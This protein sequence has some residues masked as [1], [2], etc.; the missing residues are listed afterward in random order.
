MGHTRSREPAQHCI[1]SVKLRQVT[2]DQKHR[3]QATPRPVLSQ[4]ENREKQKQI[5]GSRGGGVRL[6]VLTPKSGDRFNG[7]HRQ[8]DQPLTRGNPVTPGYA[9]PG[10][11]I[12]P[13]GNYPRQKIGVPC[14]ANGP[15]SRCQPKKRRASAPGPSRSP[16]G[17]SRRGGNTRPERCGRS[18]WPS[19]DPRHAALQNGGS[20]PGKGKLFFL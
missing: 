9:C 4:S 12:T 6:A 1:K 17:S 18:R 14:T 13:V 8:I 7:H 3:S 20:D 2:S 5:P 15:A 11:H 16:G 19:A 10:I